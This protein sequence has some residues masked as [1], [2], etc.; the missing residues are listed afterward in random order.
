[1]ELIVTREERR[2]VTEQ[3]LDARVAAIVEPVVESLGYRLVRVRITAA[4]GCTLQV[5]AERPDGAMAVEDCEAISRDLSPAL[6]A[7]DPIVGEYTLE[8]SSPGIDRPLVRQSDFERSTGQVAK[9]ELGVPQNGR[10]RFRGRIIGV[11]DAD[12]VLKLDKSPVGQPD[13]ARLPLRD[14]GEAK[15]VLTDDLIKAAGQK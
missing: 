7:A 14:I 11:E 1:L 10:R 15:L 8:I 9:V 4:N 13:V 2:L 6:D 5:M 3:G 12:L